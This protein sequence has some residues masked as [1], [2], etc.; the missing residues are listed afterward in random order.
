MSRS[1]MLPAVAP[2]ALE[3]SAKWGSGR[4]RPDRVRHS[5]PYCRLV[6]HRG[7]PTRQR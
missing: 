6:D 5:S 3:S 2:F 1:L 7:S 4:G